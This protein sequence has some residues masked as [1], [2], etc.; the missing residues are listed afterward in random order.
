MSRVSRRRGQ[1]RIIEALITLVMII[2]V[3]L[4]LAN[5][6]QGLKVEEPS[7]LRQYAYEISELLRNREIGEMVISDEPDW[8]MQLKTLVS[9]L[10]PP[11]I[12]YNATVISGTTGAVL[13][14]QPISNL[15]DLT[16][17]EFSEY[18]T[19]KQS[20]TVS[21]P[22]QISR[23]VRRPVYV[24]LVVDKSG[25]MD[26]YMQG[27]MKIDW[28]KDAL[29]E[30]LSYDGFN[31]TVDRIALVSFSDNAWNGTNYGGRF[32]YPLTD[33]VDAVK[34]KVNT[35]TPYGG[36]YGGLGLLY[37][38]MQLN[39]TWLSPY[40]PDPYNEDAVKIIIFMTDGMVN[41]KPKD[42]SKPWD[43]DAGDGKNII[44][45]DHDDE[46]NY[47]LYYVRY[48]DSRGYASWGWYTPGPGES[49]YYGGR[50]YALKIGKQAARQGIKIY[51]IGFG[52]EETWF[53]PV[54]LT[55]LATERYYYAASGSRLI[56]IYRDIAEEITTQYEVETEVIII[57]ITLARA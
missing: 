11:G 56:E 28:L 37:A 10:L 33:D 39:G 54:F 7:P 55:K 53:D 41:I 35:L 23:E 44:Y 57:Q 13:N 25:S 40:N 14:T 30:F 5:F 49:L 15:G 1:A 17:E 34:A 46:G 9:T 29:Q 12:Y 2:T 42:E 43:P 45:C 24:V 26:E 47:P 48:Y 31:M 36:T 16:Q 51:T 19:V 22:I 18:L 52:T 32:G 6:Y 21:I 38:T 8:E 20:Y 3:Q 4:L 27:R 50:G